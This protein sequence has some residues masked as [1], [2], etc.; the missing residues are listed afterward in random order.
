MKKSVNLIFQVHQSYA[1][2]RYRF[3]DIGN[4]HYYYDDYANETTTVWL[5]RHSYLPATSMLLRKVLQLKGALKVSFYISGVALEMFQKYAPSVIDSFKRL[6]E[7]GHVE[8]LCGTWSHSIASI[9]C[10][11]TFKEQIGM[12]KSF[13]GKLFG[14]VPITFFNAELLYSDDIGSMLF[15]FGYKA[16]IVEGA[17]PVLGWRSPDML[18]SNAI[19]PEFKLL[20]RNRKICDKI[21][22]SF[23]EQHQQ[24]FRI[25]P[26]ELLEEI[27]KTIP[28]EQ[29]VNLSFNLAL[30]ISVLSV[31]TGIFTLMETLLTGIAKSEH[32][33]FSTPSESAKTYP[34]SV[35]LSVPHPVSWADEKHDIAS[36]T[37]NELQQEALNQLFGLSSRIYKCE[38]A[39]I[40]N[41][42]NKLQATDHF[43]YMSANY[44]NKQ[45]QNRPN[46]YQTAHEAFVN[47]MN[48]VS[49]FKM[50][51]DK[52]CP[53]DVT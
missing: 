44:Y 19:R 43:Y 16:A 46:P 36:L 32:L 18:F 35:V 40:L 26:S 41:D 25:P 49:D 45:L 51:L 1:L 23:G 21:T 33:Q 42:W 5:A 37:G 8:F 24:N 4:D 10:R 31:E 28:G 3:F 52:I 20:M 12:H 48:I 6:A 47:Y 11:D 34:P 27:E 7:T 15:D 39:E 38:N 22:G 2:R 50:R 53:A 13:V 30:P 14:Q 9:K 17:K 29:V